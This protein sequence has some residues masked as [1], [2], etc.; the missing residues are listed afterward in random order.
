MDET[1]ERV[2]IIEDQ[3]DMPRE[4]DLIP[5]PERTD[6]VPTLVWR[7]LFQQAEKVQVISSFYL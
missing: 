1:N 2:T 3:L 6:A 4:K 7:T 5:L